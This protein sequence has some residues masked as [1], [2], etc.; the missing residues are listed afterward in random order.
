M[1]WASSTRTEVW[2]ERGSLPG[3]EGSFERRLMRVLVCLSVSESWES[4][5][6]RSDRV[7]IVDHTPRLPFVPSSIND[8]D[9]LPVSSGDV[10][11]YNQSCGVLWCFSTSHISLSLLPST[12]LALDMLKVGCTLPCSVQRGTLPQSCI[13]PRWTLVRF[14]NARGCRYRAETAKID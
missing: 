4:W 1:S 2:S 8:V 7:D 10:S 9:C 3:S 13:S 5:F 14:R 6:V 12:S 11:R